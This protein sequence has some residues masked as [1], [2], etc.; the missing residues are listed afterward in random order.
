MKRFYLF[1]LLV[2]FVISHSQASDSDLKLWYDKPSKQ[3]VEA[4]PLGNGRIGAMVFS[5]V[6]DEEFQLNEETIWGGSPHNNTNNLAK[7]HLEQI[8]S[9]IFQGKSVEAQELCGKYISAQSANGMPYQT[10]GSL[11]LKFE[12][13]SDYSNYYREL[14]LNRALS[15]T[16]FTVDGVIYTRECFISFV[17][18]LFIVR[19][20]AS[21]KGKI[22][23]AAQYTT[24][25]QDAQ[26][27]IDD[28]MLRLDGKS[29]NWEGVEGKVRFT[30]LTRIVNHGGTISYDRNSAI[31]VKGANSVLIY[32]SIGTN[33][34]NYKDVSGDS[35]RVAKGYFSN[36]AQKSYNKQLDDHTRHYRQQFSR[37][38]LDLGRN[39][40]A[41][42]P[43]D[44]RVREFSTTFDPQM[45]ALYFQFG[46]YL[47]ICS[48]QPK[49]QAANLQ[50]IWNHML[51]PP[52]DGKYT[53]DI[54]VQMNYWPAEITNLAQTHEPF[55]Q[56]IRDVAQSG[57]QTAQMYGVRG[58]TLHHN[59]DIWRSTGAVDGARWGIWPT[60]NAW[61]CQHL[62]D[63]YLFSGDK[64]YLK[65]V[66][67]IMREACNFYFDFLI[68][69]PKTGFLVVSPSNSPE[70]IPPGQ[71]AAVT[72]GVTMDN[73]MVFDLLSNTI[74]AAQII[75]PDDK[76]FIDQL[77]STLEQISPMRIGRYG[78]LQEWIEDWDSPEDKHRHVS[79][80][81]GLY[82][83][84]Q[85]SPY[86]TPE[87]FE[88]A[89]TSL[90]HRG[91]EST[92]WSMGWKVSLWAR[93]L[94]GDHAYKLIRDQIKPVVGE[95]SGDGGT[96]PNL[97]DACPPFQ[98]DGNFG[99]T[100]GI[101]EML[102]QS[103]D[104]AIDILP[105]LPAAW[106]Q[107]TV[108]GLRCRGGFVIEEL[109]WSKGMV[110]KLVI[111]STIGGVLPVRYKEPLH[112]QGI[113]YEDNPL[114]T[115][116]SVKPPI[117]STEYK[118]HKANR[119]NYVVS[120]I[121]TKPNTSYNLKISKNKK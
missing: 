4:L 23:F 58:W 115:L 95:W 2:F 105:A 10:V 118:T 121:K 37:V 113:D 67:P 40:Q 117:I 6:R 9:L 31:N 54:N 25:Y 34:V 106:A 83:G 80:L 120:E 93:L 7:E 18:Q 92:G 91:D 56:L 57:R 45:S 114:F 16:R 44:Q 24:P 71:S 85:I 61:L 84:R 30:A 17:D 15:T 110:T 68:R 66:Y 8:R 22:S 12:H 88:A 47:L 87:L 35:Y 78:Q 107:G 116:Q 89:R 29:S 111:R 1:I 102:V 75:E 52:W 65:S 69:D 28:N 11:K 27:S 100:A 90:I 38:S 79:H 103:H 104:G 108:K 55:I 70:N 21:Q 32:T 42:K 76:A 41:L 109:S 101:A 77:E 60:C 94:D 99:C 72:Y 62:W 82:P 49:G 36:V 5:G 74:Q 112:C 53:T 119:V 64:E 50:G 14:D 51:Y 13:G 96:Y 20:T 73:Q 39:S 43:T 63:R 19:L 98:I 26:V 3:W 59:T 33:F 46:R 97:L 48:S 86:N 81:W